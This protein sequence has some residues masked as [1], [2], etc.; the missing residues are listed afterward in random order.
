VFSGVKMDKYWRPGEQRSPDRLAGLREGNDKR[1][2]GR[3][4]EIG[5]R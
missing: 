5:E 3:I 4:G 2:E 1:G